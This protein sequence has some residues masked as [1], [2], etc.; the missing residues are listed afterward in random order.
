MKRYV[1]GATLIELMVAVV[2]IGIL[3]AV[4]VPS[5]RSYV[6]RSVRS[7]AQG[8][9]IEALARAERFFGRNNRYPDTIGALYGTSEKTRAC[10]DDDDF[11]AS[12]NDSVA[13][14]TSRCIELVAS[15]ESDRA[16]ASGSLHLRY[17][18]REPATTRESRWRLYQE[19]RL[20]W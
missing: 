6:E 17:D 7:D 9:L 10:T 11:S 1:R 18:P 14:P 8:C 15:P 12:I 19:T 2:I 5:Y 3:A 16:A 20:D 4:A 13:C